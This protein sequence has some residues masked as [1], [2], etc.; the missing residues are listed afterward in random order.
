MRRERIP[1]RDWG[2]TSGLHGALRFTHME[3]TTAHNCCVIVATSVGAGYQAVHVVPWSFPP[4]L[5]MRLLHDA[6]RVSSRHPAYFYF[7]ARNH[8]VSGKAQLPYPCSLL[9]R[10]AKQYVILH[11]VALKLDLSVDF[12]LISSQQKVITIATEAYHSCSPPP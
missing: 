3:V 4:V 10:T 7:L 9:P 11:S 6:E 1:R 8:L 5:T 2:W 12:L